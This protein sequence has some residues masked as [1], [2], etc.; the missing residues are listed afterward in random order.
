LTRRDG[1]PTTGMHVEAGAICSS[2]NGACSKTVQ[3]EIAYLLIRKLERLSLRAVA[4]LLM[5]TVHD[6]GFQQTREFRCMSSHL[7]GHWHV[8]H[9]VRRPR[10]D[11]SVPGCTAWLPKVVPW[12]CA[13]ASAAFSAG[14]P[15]LSKEIVHSFHGSA[16]LKCDMFAWDLQIV[17]SWGTTFKNRLPKIP[18]IR[19]ERLIHRERFYRASMHCVSHGIRS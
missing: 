5:S 11:Y 1:I 14:P 8:H 4:S 13:G 19:P 18:C 3:T 7:N 10:M 15:T 9:C 17:C 2:D 16:C 12:M 6:G